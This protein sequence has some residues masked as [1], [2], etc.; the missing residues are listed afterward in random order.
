MLLA[1]KNEIAKYQ[2]FFCQN[3]NEVNNHNT[4]LANETTNFFPSLFL[5]YFVVAVVVVA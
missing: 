1:N 3:T 2:L 4:A 5:Y